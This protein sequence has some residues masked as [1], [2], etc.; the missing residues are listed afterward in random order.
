[1]K[2]RHARAAGGRV[3][4]AVAFT[5]GAAGLA[6]CGGDDGGTVRNLNQEEEITSGSTSGSPSGTESTSP[7][8]SESGSPSESGS[9]SEA[10]ASPTP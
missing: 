6:A 9:A 8:T 3:A 5:F 2:L 1:M 7:S 4:V 10:S